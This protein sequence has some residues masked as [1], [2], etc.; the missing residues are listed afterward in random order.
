MTQFIGSFVELF[1]AACCD[2]VVL[3]NCIRNAYIRSGKK[4]RQVLADCA[5]A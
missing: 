5:R 1:L 4:I 3:P 2:I